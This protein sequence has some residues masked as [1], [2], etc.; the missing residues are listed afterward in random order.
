MEPECSLMH[1]RWP[2][3]CPYPVS[4]SSSPCFLILLLESPFN[5]SSHLRIGLIHLGLL[6]KTLYKPLLSPILVTCSAHHI[7]LDLST[8]IRDEE[9]RS[10]SSALCSLLHSPVNFSLLGPN[11]IHR[12]IFSNSSACFPPSLSETKLR[13]RTKQKTKLQIFIS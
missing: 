9:Y 1:S 6:V 3:N 5:I 4:D 12:T 10:S 8:R 11:I 13:T 7:L 2:A